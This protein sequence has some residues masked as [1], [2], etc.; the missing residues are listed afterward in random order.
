MKC[1]AY[2]SNL[3]KFGQ[4]TVYDALDTPIL[5]NVFE[6]Q[7]N[8]CVEFYLT[9]CFWDSNGD[10]YDP[11]GSCPSEFRGN[12]AALGTIAKKIEVEIYKQDENYVFFEW[13]GFKIEKIFHYESDYEGNIL[14][15]TGFYKFVFGG[16]I[17]AE[18]RFL[19]TT[20]IYA[21]YSDI[22]LFGKHWAKTK[23]E[24]KALYKRNFLNFIE[25]IKYAARNI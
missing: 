22:F 25:Q 5:T 11:K 2:K 20:L 12:T 23:E 9:K 24:R 1:P 8:K 18:G 17:R 10:F 16:L 3:V 15:K 7:N 14:K 4:K 21:I 6:C 19:L 13:R